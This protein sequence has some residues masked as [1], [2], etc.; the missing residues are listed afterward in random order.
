MILTKLGNHSS[1]IDTTAVQALIDT[2][3]EVEKWAD[4]PVEV[5]VVTILVHAQE[6]QSC[7]SHLVPLRHGVVPLDSTGPC[8]W[9][10]WYRG[11]IIPYP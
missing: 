8:R 1:H 11:G 6:T 5:H 7:L 2:R 9:R 10:F 4:H 3:N